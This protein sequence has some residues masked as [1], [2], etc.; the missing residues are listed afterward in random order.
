MLLSSRI[1]KVES[2]K[3]KNKIFNG[4]AIHSQKQK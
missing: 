1:Q 3:E 2:K 4:N